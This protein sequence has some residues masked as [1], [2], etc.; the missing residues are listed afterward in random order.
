MQIHEL[1]KGGLVGVQSLTEKPWF[2]PGML[3]EEEWEP[4]WLWDGRWC[5]RRGQGDQG[6][7]ARQGGLSC[8]VG[9]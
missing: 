8:R 6:S 9:A 4:G 1:T 2:S 3:A 5:W 7:T